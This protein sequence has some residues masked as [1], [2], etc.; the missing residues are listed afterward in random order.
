MNLPV[1]AG[2]GFQENVCPVSVSPLASQFSEHP[3]FPVDFASRLGAYGK[4]AAAAGFAFG[5]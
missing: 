4:L 5:T 3:A 2:W 1:A